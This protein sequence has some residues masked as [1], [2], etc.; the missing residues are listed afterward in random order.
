MMPLSL[1]ATGIL[2]ETPLHH[3]IRTGD[4]PMTFLMLHIDHKLSPPV[5]GS[6]DSPRLTPDGSV[7]GSNVGFG[8]SRLA[9][10]AF[11]A[12]HVTKH[13]G[14]LNRKSTIGGFAAL[15]DNR[16]ILN[17]N[18]KNTEANHSPKT[19]YDR[20]P[21]VGFRPN[22]DKMFIGWRSPT[23]TAA[24]SR[25]PDV[26][27]INDL[28][29]RPL[30][31]RDPNVA[32]SFSLI[33]NGNN[34][35][36]FTIKDG[37]SRSLVHL[38]A[39]SR[40]K[41]NL[42]TI[43][44]YDECQK[45]ANTQD[46]K[47][48]TP[49]HSIFSG[50]S[51]HDR[52]EDVIACVDLL[53]SHVSD[54]N[55]VNIRG[56]TA[57][58]AAAKKKRPDSLQHL[59]NLRGDPC[60]ASTSLWYPLHAACHSGCALC[61]E[62]LLNTGLVT[63]QISQE[64]LNQ[65]VPFY[66]ATCSYSLSCLKVL[67]ENGDH[68]TNEDSGGTSRCTHLLVNVPTAG[69]FLEDLFDDSIT[70]CA[71]RPFEADFTVTF[72]YS[73]LLSPKLEDVQCSLISELTSRPLE[74]LFTHP[75]IETFLFIKWKRI[76]PF[77]YTN[78]AVYFLFLMLHTYYVMRTFGP[79][80]SDW[81]NALV[82]LSIFRL[83]HI[84]VFLMI[85]I[86]DMIIMLANFKKY[87]LQWET[88]VK[89]ITLSTSAFI[90]FSQRVET[91]GEMM[92][93]KHVAAISIFFAWVE[94]M[95]L[96][97]RFPV[98]GVYILMFTKV[99]KSIIKFLFAFSSLLIGFSIAF[100][101]I[102]GNIPAF[103]SFPASLV[104]TLMM[105]IGEIDYGTLVEGNGT[106]MPVLGYISLVAFLF[107]VPIIL[108][109][110][111]IGLAVSDLPDLSRQGKI[112]RLSKQASYLQ[113]YELLIL[114]FKELRCFPHLVRIVLSNLA[115]IKS[116]VTIFPNKRHSKRLRL[117]RESLPSETLDTA[118]QIL[119]KRRES[120]RANNYYSDEDEEDLF[121]KKSNN[122]LKKV[123]LGRRSRLYSH[124]RSP[125]HRLHSHDRS[126]RLLNEA[127]ADNTF[128]TKSAELIRQE[129]RDIY[130][131]FE[132][133]YKREFFSLRQYIR[134]NIVYSSHHLQHHM[135][136]KTELVTEKH[137][138]RKVKKTVCVKAKKIACPPKTKTKV[139][140]SSRTSP[141]LEDPAADAAINFEAVALSDEQTTHQGTSAGS[142]TLQGRPSQARISDGVDYVSDAEDDHHRGVTGDLVSTADLV[143]IMATLESKV[144][145]QTN[146]IQTLLDNI[147]H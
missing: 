37:N 143:R 44:G 53:I 78:F 87:L 146:L 59:L 49:L 80:S 137:P 64:T 19:F 40:S 83:F 100:G 103:Q 110:L 62:H 48:N 54:V 22:S 70:G 20:L 109:N 11:P 71:Q 15:T 88:F 114:F 61:V 77:F 99:A 27:G 104:K 21:S 133:E 29:S 17:Y 51:C 142:A 42:A 138:I 141:V 125:R 102:F 113:A 69:K 139:E 106:K 68:L 8:T 10:P 34:D 73:I 47:G 130:D 52:E 122:I 147:Q 23:A 98:L 3:A 107:L 74:D 76:K 119:V 25:R 127:A 129:I 63:D 91:S 56:E 95:M 16:S 18:I 94:L 72:D 2:R 89:L 67:L 115:K 39:M 33:P 97:G 6:T 12:S 45:L 90:V 75:L 58:F 26:N 30:L 55:A 32:E 43:L 93:E 105:M 1:T 131:S 35:P 81:S 135:A 124:D 108:A 28:I 101:I 92:A 86:P 112:R 118:T 36:D 136:H 7:Y 24:N 84:I 120:N 31:A 38:A 60:I 4:E 41:K 126:A 144:S 46:V 96:L 117:F 116:K 65:K 134:T 140:E 145:I 79:N 9:G 50:I 132:K 66:L 128:D 13:G 121:H 111:L 85:M 14:P 5:I 82:M 57:L 123:S